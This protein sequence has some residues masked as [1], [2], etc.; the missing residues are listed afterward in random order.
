MRRELGECFSGE[1]QTGLG[2][3]GS[4]DR[5]L[6]RG[7][8]QGTY[9]DEVCDDFHFFGGATVNSALAEEECWPMGSGRT[10]G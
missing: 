4:H 9:F 7:F 3:R 1:G 6:F 5:G 8:G 2:S 10:Q